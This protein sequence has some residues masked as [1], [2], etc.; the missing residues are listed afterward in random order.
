MGLILQKR[1]AGDWHF[2][3]TL[4][5]IPACE[6]ATYLAATY[7][8]RAAEFRIVEDKPL[9]AATIRAMD[10]RDWQDIGPA[11]RRVPSAAS[12]IIGKLT[13]KSDHTPA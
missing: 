7:G 2:V 4:V 5:P 11:K 12:I 6:R 8:K 13:R 1:V 9:P 3:Q 10:R